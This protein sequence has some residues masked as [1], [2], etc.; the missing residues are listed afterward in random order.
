MTFPS[1]VKV[2]NEMEEE[3]A[4][5]NKHIL[6]EC[7]CQL[8]SVIERCCTTRKGLHRY[9]RKLAKLPNEPGMVPVRLLVCNCSSSTKKREDSDAG[10]VPVKS[11]LLKSSVTVLG[12]QKIICCESACLPCKVTTNTIPSYLAVSIDPGN[13]EWI[14]LEHYH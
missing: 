9:V 1:R 8:N 5:K 11:L 14:V 3:F 10:K 7:E 13:L 6:R 4:G 12:L 2:P